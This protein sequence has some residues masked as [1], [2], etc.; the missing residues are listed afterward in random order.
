MG[1]GETGTYKT[2]YLLT[3]ILTSWSRVLLG[4]LAGLQPAKEFPTFYGTRRF[5]T[6]Y[7]TARHLSLSEASSIQSMPPHPTS[8][9]SI[10]TLSSHL[11]LGLLS[12]LFPSGFPI[13]T[14]N[15]PLLST[16]TR[17]M[18]RPS[19]AEYWVSSTV[20]KTRYTR[21]LTIYKHGDIWV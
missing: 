8:W 11:Y 6:A 20:Y 7:T 21:K 15:T 10:V 16:Q 18:P 17:Y 13:K 2:W 1:W 14:L 3:Y 5:I 9:R 19:P 12:G 4:K